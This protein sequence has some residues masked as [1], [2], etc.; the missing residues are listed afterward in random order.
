MSLKTPLYS[1]WIIIYYM[2]ECDFNGY[3]EIYGSASA[4]ELKDLLENN[5][6]ILVI[7][8]ENGDQLPLGLFWKYEHSK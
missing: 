6:E 7:D 3:T 5:P 2:G 4:K 8:T 1:K